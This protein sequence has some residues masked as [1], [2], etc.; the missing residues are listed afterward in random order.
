MNKVAIILVTYNSQLHLPKAMECLEKQSLQ[1]TQIIIVDTGSTDK[2]YLL[3]YQKNPVVEVVYAPQDAGFCVGNNIGWE[4]LAASIEYVFFLNPDAFLTESYL[5]QAVC[6]MRNPSHRACGALTGITLRY[7]MQN[8]RSTSIYDTTGIF[9]TWYG[10]WYDRAQGEIY[11]P[12]RFPTIEK[13]PA[14]CGAVLFCRKKA[15]DAVLIS[16]KEVFNSNFYM[17]KED[18]DLSLRLQKKKW[19]LLFHPDLLAYHCRG[20]TPRRQNMPR[21]MRLYS[22]QNELKINFKHSFPFGAAY[23]FLKYCAVKF[24]D[25]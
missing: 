21:K 10:R 13:I 16:N 2:S 4:K 6:I 11:E 24:F 19:H 8:N 14:I 23:S 3:K 25:K 1:P 15:V 20:W 17:Y 7:D 18:I 5:E 22:A 12:G 9:K